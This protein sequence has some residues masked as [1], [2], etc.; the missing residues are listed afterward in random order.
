MKQTE[1][2]NQHMEPQNKRFSKVR[3][4]DTKTLL[5]TRKRHMGFKYAD[6]SKG[7]QFRLIRKHEG[8]NQ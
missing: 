3:Q 7:K 1:V 6:Y 2:N 5:C 8:D 4:V